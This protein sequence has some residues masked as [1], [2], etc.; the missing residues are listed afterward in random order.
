MSACG[1]TTAAEHREIENV[2]PTADQYARAVRRARKAIQMWS[3]DGD[4]NRSDDEWAQD[5]F[6]GA[7]A[8][9]VAHD[10]LEGAVGLDARLVDD[11]E[12]A[13]YDIDLDGVELEIKNRKL[14]DREEPD[15]LIRRRT[16]IDADCY[17]LAEIDRDADS[18][19]VN[20]AGW[21]SQ[22]EVA[23]YA[24]DFFAGYHDKLLVER[25]HLRGVATLP[26]YM[27]AL[28]GR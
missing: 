27:G 28:A 20:I 1:Q 26:E 14:W 23:A 2:R 15:M 7:L 8:E 6:L 17:L 9:V 24:R 22:P 4:L 11:A 5:V 21:V 13:S 12:D 25:K 16:P 18:H 3:N 10:E 19:L